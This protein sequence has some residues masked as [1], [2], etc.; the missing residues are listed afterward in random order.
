MIVIFGDRMQFGQRVAPSILSSI[1]PSNEMKGK[2]SRTSRTAMEEQDA[3]RLADWFMLLNIF[4]E[5]C[6]AF[7]FTN[8]ISFHF[9]IL[10]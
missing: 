5:H 3:R 10:K 8:F 7:S 4:S 2:T 6:E 9:S 1:D